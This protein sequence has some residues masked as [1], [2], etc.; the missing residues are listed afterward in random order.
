MR[1]LFVV[2][3]AVILG[4]AAPASAQ[5]SDVKK[6]IEQIASKYVENFNKQDAGGIAS[7]YTKDGSLV[8]PSTTIVKTGPQAIEQY[9]QA[10]FKSGLNHQ[11]A[12]VD[13]V[14]PLGNDTAISMG[15]YEIAGQG[16]SG[17]MKAEGHWTAVDVRAGGAWKITLLT[18]FPNPLPSA[19]SGPPVPSTTR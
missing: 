9:Y 11:V 16:Q 6:E 5:Q 8:S 2:L 14:T 18:A 19:G 13:Q 17:P 1:A 15:T 4:F 10:G 12:V 7:L 3:A